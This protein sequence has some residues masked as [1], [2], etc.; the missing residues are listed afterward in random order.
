MISQ[1]IND[2]KDQYQKT[3]TEAASHERKVKRWKRRV[4]EKGT[5]IFMFSHILFCFAVNNQV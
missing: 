3:K 2:L 1:A 4:R 5:S